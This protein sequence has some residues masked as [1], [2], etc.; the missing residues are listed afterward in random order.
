M[1]YR[2]S[3]RP[4]G[5]GLGAL[6]PAERR[7]TR[8]LTPS[9]LRPCGC[10]PLTPMHIHIELDLCSPQSSLPSCAQPPC[11]RLPSCTGAHYL[12]VSIGPSPWP[13][14][15]R[16]PSVPILRRPHNPSEC[17]SQSTVRSCHRRAS[18]NRVKPASHGTQTAQ[19]V[20]S[21]RRHAV[22]SSSDCCLPRRSCAAVPL[23]R[24]P[25]QQR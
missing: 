25:S 6:T 10:G 7:I 1:N 19:H 14:P 20:D 9:F 24:P 12:L 23:D 21:D 3:S 22:R 18:I 8:E 2:T 11:C 5:A 15:T 17:Q 13:G 16:A 4:S